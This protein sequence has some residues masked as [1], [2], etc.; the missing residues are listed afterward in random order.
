[1]DDDSASVPHAPSTVDLR[2][3]AVAAVLIAGGIALA[4]AFPWVIIAHSPSPS[5]APNNAKRPEIAGAVLQ[6]APSTDLEAF[7]REKQAEARK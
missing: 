7:R 1:M 3:I 2:A 6:T 5:N 4:V